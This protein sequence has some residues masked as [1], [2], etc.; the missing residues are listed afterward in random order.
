M[1]IHH[2]TDVVLV[3]SDLDPV[4]IFLPPHLHLPLAPK[5]MAAG[6]IIS[7]QKPIRLAPDE[8]DQPVAA[9]EARGRPMKLFENFIFH[10]PV[11]P[12]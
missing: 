10:P 4:G 3:R 6:S 12:P 1:A 2:D 9:A 7:M 11:L 8:A 5:A